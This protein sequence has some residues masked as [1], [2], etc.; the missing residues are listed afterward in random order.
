MVLVHINGHL[1]EDL[2][3]DE[4]ARIS[5][6]SP[7][8]FHRIFRAMVGESVS[9]HVR[10]LRLELAAVRLKQ[11]N[12]PIIE[13]ALGARYES[14]ESFTRAFKAMFGV[15]PSEFR[16]Q[17]VGAPLPGSG[18]HAAP[19]KLGA[20]DTKGTDMKVEV[21]GLPPQ[22]IAFVRHV[23]P[24][25]E[26]GSAFDKLMMWAGPRGLFVPGAMVLG[27][28]Y[29]DPSITSAGKLRYDAAITLDSDDDAEPE[30]EVGVRELA[31]GDYAVVC[32]QGPYSGLTATYDFMYGRWLPASGYDLTDAP[33]FEHYLNH[34]DSTDPED[35]VTDVHIPLVTRGLS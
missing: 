6:F 31:G 29:D 4:L 10:R 35:L 30:G 24:Y 17:R 22:R 7:F 33:P 1:E 3:L 16:S 20:P 12:S 26:V 13:L 5:H 11:T 14:H 19:E 8:H 9:Q 34:P 18:V 2:S 23:G 28:S 15:A 25:D 21:V 27:I 32:H